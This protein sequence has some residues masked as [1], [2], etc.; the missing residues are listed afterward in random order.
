MDM[1]LYS[2]FTKIESLYK[3][4]RRITIIELR[5]RVNSN[6]LGNWLVKPFLT[7]YLKTFGIYLRQPPR[8]PRQGNHCYYLAMDPVFNIFLNLLTLLHQKICIGFIITEK[9][10]NMPHYHL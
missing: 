7:L 10:N 6:R 2:K 3:T 8:P 1:D 4:S 5:Y 9:R